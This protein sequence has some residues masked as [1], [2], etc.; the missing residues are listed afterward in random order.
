M[1]AEVVVLFDRR[2]LRSHH[3]EFDIEV[4]ME[5]STD[6]VPEARAVFGTDRPPLAALTLRDGV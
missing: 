3:D 6:E 5:E 2:L 1:R 4:H